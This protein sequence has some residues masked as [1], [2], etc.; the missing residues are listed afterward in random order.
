MLTMPP[1]KDCCLRCKPRDYVHPMLPPPL[2]EAPMPIGPNVFVTKAERLASEF[3]KAFTVGEDLLIRWRD[4]KYV[5]LRRADG[6][7]QIFLR[8]DLL[9]LI[10]V[11]VKSPT[12]PH[13]TDALIRHVWREAMPQML[14]RSLRQRGMK[15]VA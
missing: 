9:E 4:A 13:P 6:C 2:A 5:W 7:E 8:G 14:A 1:S 11:K 3:L 12:L 10:R 15:A